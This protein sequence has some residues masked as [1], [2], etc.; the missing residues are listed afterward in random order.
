MGFGSLGFRVSR[1]FTVVCT[2]SL[3]FQSGIYYICTKL[4]YIHHGHRQ[5]VRWVVLLDSLLPPVATPTTR[6]VE[7]SNICI[8]HLKHITL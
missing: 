1:F 6:L 4:T 2:Q 5:I 3:D 8:K 7:K